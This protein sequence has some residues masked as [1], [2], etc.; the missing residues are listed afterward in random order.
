[1]QEKNEKGFFK[2]SLLLELSITGNSQKHSH[3]EVLCIVIIIFTF[4][5]VEEYD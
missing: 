4:K 2:S 3:R 1:M 5:W